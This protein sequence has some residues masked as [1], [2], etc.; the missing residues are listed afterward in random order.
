MN[1]KKEVPHEFKVAYNASLKSKINFLAKTDL[2]QIKD[3]RMLKI[4]RD[5]IRSHIQSVMI[6]T[7]LHVEES[8]MSD[9]QWGFSEQ[10]VRHRP[11]YRITWWSAD[12]YFLDFGRFERRTSF[13]RRTK[14]CQSSSEKPNG[15]NRTVRRLKLP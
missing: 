13:E 10:G 1:S 3:V 7:S 5:S 14:D 2:E 15:P 11:R 9:S 4:F 12:Q 8:C 6:N